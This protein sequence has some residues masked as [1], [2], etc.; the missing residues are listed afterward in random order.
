MSSNY[1][2]IPAT[3]RNVIEDFQL[4]DNLKNAIGTLWTL[5]LQINNNNQQHAE[6][7]LQNFLNS[8]QVYIYEPETMSQHINDEIDILNLRIDDNNDIFHGGFSLKRRKTG[9]KRKRTTIKNSR[10]KRKRRK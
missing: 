9:K 7:D 5:Y 1:D 6:G 4:N 3:T 8:I 10:K 2:S